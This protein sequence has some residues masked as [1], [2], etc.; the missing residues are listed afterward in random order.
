MIVSSGLHVLSVRP[1][2]SWWVR[3]GADPIKQPTPSPPS[4][5]YG[6][7]QLRPSY[8]RVLVQEQRGRRQIDTNNDLPPTTASGR[9]EPIHT[10]VEMECCRCLSHNPPHRARSQPTTHHML[11]IVRDTSSRP[12]P[13]FVR[14]LLAR[15]ISQSTHAAT[16]SLTH[17]DVPLRV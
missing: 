9:K 10:Y 8:G 12:H 1:I 3:E 7:L 13:T 6:S 2:Q 16:R 14:H 5:R 17:A 11:P 4:N 15:F